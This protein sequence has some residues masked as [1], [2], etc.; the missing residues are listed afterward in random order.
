MSN[1]YRNKGG[2]SKGSLAGVVRK[3]GSD[4]KEEN[5]HLAYLSSL[6]I[7]EAKALIGKTI[8]K[9]ES[10]KFRLILTFSDG[11]TLDVEGATPNFK[12]D[13]P[14]SLDAQVNAR[15]IKIKS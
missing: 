13:G 12:G 11:S 5:I 2:D 14:D 4:Y 1:I 8:T 6:T 3:P 10:Y 7:K 9:I 15:T